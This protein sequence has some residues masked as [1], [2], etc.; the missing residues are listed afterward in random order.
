MK[1]EGC[2][3]MRK[4]KELGNLDADEWIEELCKE[5]NQLLGFGEHKNG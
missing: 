1:L 2:D 4:A 5:L 3:D